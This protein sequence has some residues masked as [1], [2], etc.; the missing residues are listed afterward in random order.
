MEELLRLLKEFDLGRS[1]SHANGRMPDP[2]FGDDTELTSNLYIDPY[3][4]SFSGSTSRSSSHAL[5]ALQ[6]AKRFFT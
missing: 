6:L 4:A 2:S 1:S 5:R 3:S